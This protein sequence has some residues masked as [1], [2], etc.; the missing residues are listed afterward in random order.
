MWRIHGFVGRVLNRCYTSSPL[1]LSQGHHVEDDVLSSSSLLSSNLHPPEGSSQRGEK[2]DRQRQERT[3][4]HYSP[5]LPRYTA[6]EAV[7]WGAAAVLVLQIIKRVHSQFSSPSEQN[8]YR[9]RAQIHRCGY[10]LLVEILSRRD[11][12]PRSVN[13]S[14]LRSVEDRSSSSNDSSEQSAE[15]S[16]PSFS[17]RV[18]PSHDSKGPDA[19]SFEEISHLEDTGVFENLRE[20]KKT[21]CSPEEELTGAVK[22]LKAVTDANVPVILNII[23]LENA[24]RGDYQTAFLCFLAAANQ[25]YS[26]AQFSAGVCYETG[27]GV[28]RDIEK[29]ALYYR[30]AAAAGHSRAQFRYAKYLLHSKAQPDAD[31][32]HKA[33]ALLEEAAGA[34]LRE[35]Q[36]YLGALFSREPC[37]DGKN[38]VKFL[39]MAAKSG[40][41]HSQFNLGQCYETGFGVQ[42]CHIT[43]VDHYQQAAAAG[44]RQAHHILTAIY[45]SGLSEDVLLRSISSSP[46]FSTAGGFCHGSD[47]PV[48]IEDLTG[49][50]CLTPTLAHSWSTGSIST[51]PVMYSVSD[52]SAELSEAKKSL[53]ANLRSQPAPCTWT[54][55]VG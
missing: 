12:L 20:N 38:A 2:G 44:S 22:T 53:T 18:S 11:V 10:R 33:I 40:D 23:G 17:K 47:S 36:A 6:L 29:A 25:G 4:H 37:R 1:R 50:R 24:K 14:C 30:Q 21:S 28:V 26:K 19:P 55:G 15:E 5:G 39:R 8:Q 34:G 45:G 54:I 16:S 35:A 9:D 7:G 51:R 3:F 52:L 42:Q 48:R 41:S 32:T 49:P 46:C 27:R 13:A 31:D 43:A